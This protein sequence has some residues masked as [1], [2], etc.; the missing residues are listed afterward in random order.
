V[1]MKA[2][3]KGNLSAKDSLALQYDA[4]EIM[5]TAQKN[6]RKNLMDATGNANKPAVQEYVRTGRIEKAETAMPLVATAVVARET[7]GNKLY[8]KGL[9]LLA[10][11]ISGAAAAAESDRTSSAVSLIDKM[12]MK[13]LDPVE[14]AVS[15]M[16]NPAALQEMAKPIMTA[17]VD[18]SHT[19]AMDAM[20]LKD[21]A[22]AM[23][24]GSF[25]TDGRIDEKQVLAQ[26]EQRKVNVDE[27]MSKLREASRAAAQKLTTPTGKGGAAIASL[28][29]L[30]FNNQAEDYAEDRTMFW[31]REAI[32]GKE[33]GIQRAKDFKSTIDSIAY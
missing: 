23:R 16:S 17:V 19:L 20:G 2:A 14:L 4:L 32:K 15:A 9:E 1:K 24:N 6:V 28:N 5:Q 8:D 21:V 13:D 12:A 10:D 26:L 18:E 25:Y 7:T 30:Y 11:K 29:K 3:E 33:A 27:Y 31:F 22:M